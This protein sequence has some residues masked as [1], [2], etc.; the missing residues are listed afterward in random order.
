[1][2]KLHYRGPNGQFADFELSAE[3]TVIGRKTAVSCKA[4]IQLDGDDVSREHAVI[5]SDGDQ[6][7]IRDDTSRNHTWLGNRDITGQGPQELQHGDRI[8]IR[9]HSLTFVDPTSSSASSMQFRRDDGSSDMYPS[10]AISLG[11][12]TSPGKPSE[13]SRRLSALIQISRSLQDALMLDDVLVNALDGLFEIFPRAERG[14]IGIRE[15]NGD[16]VPRWWRCRDPL[17]HDHPPVSQTIVQRVAESREATLFDMGLA[18]LPDTESVYRLPLGAVICAPLAAADGEVNGV[19]QIDAPRSGGFDQADLELVAAVAVQVSLA[20][21]MAQLHQSAVQQQVVLRDLSNAREMQQTF[22]PERPPRVAGYEF[23]SY[24]EPAQSVGGDYFDFVPLKDGRIAVVLADVGGKGVPAA[25][26]MARLATETRTCLERYPEAT[27]V[28]TQLN[29]RLTTCF[30]TFSMAVIDPAR[31]TVT[32]VI[33][34]HRP[35]T[36]RHRDGTLIPA[37]ASI[38][39]LPFSATEDAEFDSETL[40]FE[41]GD[42][43][44]MFSDGFEDALRHDPDERFGIRRLQEL[45]AASDGTAAEAVDA[46]VSSVHD[47]TGDTPQFDDMCLVAVRREPEN[48][49]QAAADNSAVPRA[50]K[51]QPV[52]VLNDPCT[53]HS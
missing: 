7:L 5:Y 2:A 9:Q 14:I 34:G 35:P 23:A 33:A 51:T 1:L 37:G 44:V 42:T 10:S 38:V 26:Y 49:D 19:L 15:D 3:R 8:R 47:F 39:G 41:P 48:N 28:I 24:Y 46:I 32:I 13:A 11:R 30:V 21:N 27:D 22:L 52:P 53:S 12:L 36:F 16:F 50:A 29:R 18:S 4:D 6:F 45:I 20:I 31:H 25:L 43:L 40:P 17:G